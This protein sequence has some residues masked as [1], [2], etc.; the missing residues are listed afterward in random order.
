MKWVCLHNLGI[1]EKKNFASKYNFLRGVEIEQ[2][3]TAH[4][5]LVLLQPQMQK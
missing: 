1:Q 4:L 5:G 3:P 2:N